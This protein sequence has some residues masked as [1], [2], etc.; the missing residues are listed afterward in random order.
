KC[1]LGFNP[2]QVRNARN[3]DDINVLALGSDFIDFDGAKRIVKSFLETPFDPAERHQRRIKKIEDLEGGDW[4]NSQKN[5]F[6]IFAVLGTIISLSLGFVLLF[7][8]DTFNNT[9]FGAGLGLGFM[10]LGILGWKS[11]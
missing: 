9:S 5:T 11:K 3:D 4:V 6:K 2:D 7:V 8:G 10:S 1:G